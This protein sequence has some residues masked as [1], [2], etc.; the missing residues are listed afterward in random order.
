MSSKEFGTALQSGNDVI[1]GKMCVVA[2]KVRNFMRKTPKMQTCDCEVNASVTGQ[3]VTFAV[4]DR[5]VVISMKIMDMVGIITAA[6]DR[7][8][9]IKVQENFKKVMAEKNGGNQNG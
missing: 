8:K 1:K 5:N 4:P 7:Y 6:N 9:Q 3:F 2:S